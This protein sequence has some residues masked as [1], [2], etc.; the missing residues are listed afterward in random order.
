MGAPEVAVDGEVIE[1][2]PPRKLVQTWR[3]VMDEA[4]A[5]E[6]FTRLTYEIAEGKGG[7]TKLTVTHE[8]EGAPK[9]ALLMS[10]GM[11]DT[12]AGGGW[13]WVLSD[14][15]SLLETGTSLD[16][17]DPQ[18]G[19]TRR[20]GGPARRGLRRSRRP[21]PETVPPLPGTPS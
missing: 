11:E 10:G 4:M 18:P 12:G 5:A 1:A 19:M 14:L 16:W 13:S 15:K 20:G 9:L 3:M 21:I 6:G 17:Q 2:D 7:V 8:L